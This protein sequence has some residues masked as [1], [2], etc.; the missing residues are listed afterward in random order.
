MRVIKLGG[1]LLTV[2]GLANRLERWLQQQPLM[3]SLVV[4]GGGSTA[5]TVRA[6][7]RRHHL[8]ES[9]A[10][11]LAIRAMQFNARLVKAL[12]PGATLLES[13]DQWTAAVELPLVWVVDPWTMLRQDASRHVDPL[14]ESWEVTSDSIAAWIATQTKAAE[15]VLLKSALPTCSP[16]VRCAVECGY[17]DRYFAQAASMLPRM[18]C[19]NLR[20]ESFPEI[21]LCLG[22]NASSPHG[23]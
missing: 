7:D 15:L 6:F 8:D 16:T 12:L 14:P 10:H 18:R 4:V 9:T 3:P 21:E 23:P 13:F 11:W 17:V 5:H 2:D 20:E 1:S 19:V 22:S